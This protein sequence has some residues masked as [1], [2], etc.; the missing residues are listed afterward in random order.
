MCCAVQTPGNRYS[1]AIKDRL[2]RNLTT[3]GAPLFAGKFLFQ[4]SPRSTLEH[5]TYRGSVELT[6]NPIRAFV[7]QPRGRLSSLG[8]T[9]LSLRAQD[10]PLRTIDR[11]INPQDDNV[12]LSPAAQR[13]LDRVDFDAFTNRYIAATLRFISN[14]LET[15]ATSTNENMVG[16]FVEEP[17][18]PEFQL[19]MTPTINVRQVETC[20]DL[21]SQDP[22][23]GVCRNEPRF[24]A[25]GRDSGRRLYRNV[26][27]DTQTIGNVPVISVRTGQGRTA[28]LYAK[29]AR[30]VRLEVLHD[31]RAS[32][33]TMAH[34]FDGDNALSQM[35]IF[36]AHCR[37]Q[38][39]QDATHL[40]NAF[41]IDDDPSIIQESPYTLINEIYR[42]TTDQTG[43]DLLLSAL[44]NNGSYT[45]RTNDPLLRARSR[46]QHRGVLV[47]TRPRSRVYR[48]APRFQ[49]ARSVL[50]NRPPLTTVD[51]PDEQ[52]D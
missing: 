23:G 37:H 12:V 17:S 28:K 40:A 36:L 9:S 39:L 25:L 27:A 3:P 52:E 32:N 42:A 10:R 38:A 5:Q 15:A 6:L 2:T 43:R 7:H 49:E 8:E 11:P 16:M 47:S 21:P 19:E 33:G 30:K 22:I 14:L 29:T 46:L 48:L 18:F 41:E 31:M 50:A 51:V 24:R 34:T 45:H 26:H 4:S 44:I 13:A 1:I 20:W 35:L